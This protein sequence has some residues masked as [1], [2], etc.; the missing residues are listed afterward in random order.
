V[1]SVA[2]QAQGGDVEV[3]YSMDW[4][5]EEAAAVN[6][7]VAMKVQR[8]GRRRPASGSSGRHREAASV[9]G[10]EK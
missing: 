3:R 5:R 10:R 9:L 2:G 4:R 7:L 8:R 6:R 1:R